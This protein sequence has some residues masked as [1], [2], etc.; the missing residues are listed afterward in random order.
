MSELID[1]W[2]KPPA[3][4][5]M[6]AG[7]NQWADAGAV[8]SGLPVYLVEQTQARKIANFRSD[9]FYLFQIPG[10][11]HLLRPVVKLDDG[12]RERIE[13]K[14]NEFFYAGDDE[15]GFVIFSG[16]EPHL[17]EELYAEAFFDVA[18]ALGIERVAAVAGV[19]GAMPYDQDREISCV[20]SHPYMKE[21]LS[22][23]ALRFSNYEGGATISMY[24][25]DQAERRGIEFFRF[26]TFVPSYD[27]SQTS[28]PVQPIAIGE[29]YKAWHDIMVRLNYM[30]KLG[31]DLTDLQQKSE[32]LVSEWDAK[33]E[34]VAASMPQ[35]EVEEY[36][37][38][39]RSE[40]NETPFEPLSDVWKDGLRGLLDDF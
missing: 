14:Q 21:E 19:Y 9:G 27:F 23:Y 32:A 39:I 6:I 17:Y 24:L 3:A 4:K 10:T 2:E 1:I 37:E 12:H 22:R 40:F 33:I 7:W 13:E 20:Y 15:R 8:S 16:E 31:F 36:M 5:Y 38:K 26:C 28:I 35:L 34:Q 11:H 18:E 30:F 29:D 25:A